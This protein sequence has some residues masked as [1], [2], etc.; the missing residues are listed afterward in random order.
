MIDLHSHI[1]P[2]LDDGSPNMAA[3]IDM[4]ANYVANGFHHVVATPHVLP[5][6][7]GEQWAASLK[8]RVAK[9]NAALHA[10]SISLTV[11]SGM[12][13]AIAPELAVFLEAGLLLPLADSRYVLIETPFERLPTYW[14]QILFEVAG[15][16]YRVLL[17]HPERCIQL[18]RNDHLID[19]LID[20][21][22]HL[23][24]NWGS[25]TGF[26]GRPALK[27]ARHL[28]RKGYI[29]CLA[30]DSHDH[31]HRSAD[32]VRKAAPEINARIGAANLDLLSNGNPG[33]II[34][35]RPLETM[36]DTPERSKAVAGWKRWFI[37]AG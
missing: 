4:A 1:L 20:M 34:A 23:Q 11:S 6:N 27:T 16:G 14:E 9:M 36:T 32:V 31:R 33:R 21:G 25:F 12:E 29:H 13:I 7:I 2:F 19:R 15:R 28:A 24:V 10:A 26:Y 8:R 37:R 22:I 35:N 3:S 5:E 30:T 17:A 18:S